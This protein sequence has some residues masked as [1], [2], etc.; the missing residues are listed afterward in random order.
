MGY[1]AGIKRGTW[2]VGLTVSRGHCLRPRGSIRRALGVKYHFQSR[3]DHRGCGGSETGVAQGS[4]LCVGAPAVGLGL[5]T[6]RTPAPP[7]SPHRVTGNSCSRSG[8]VAGF[9]RIL[10]ARPPRPPSQELVQSWAPGKSL[11]LWSALRQGGRECFQEAALGCPRLE[12]PLTGCGR[13]SFSP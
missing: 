3:P 8:W 2:T 9:D 5:L 11:K 4:L 1:P 6:G 10:A 13:A 7:P 12:S